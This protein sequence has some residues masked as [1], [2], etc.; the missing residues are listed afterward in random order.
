MERFEKYLEPWEGVRE[1][2]K[3]ISMTLIFKELVVSPN[4]FRSMLCLHVCDGKLSSTQD[5]HHKLTSLVYRLVFN[6]ADPFLLS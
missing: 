3:Y 5:V 2:W 4:V 6:I 1:D